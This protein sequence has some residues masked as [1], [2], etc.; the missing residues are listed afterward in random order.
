MIIFNFPF[1]QFLKTPCG[2]EPDSKW[3]IISKFALLK[4]CIKDFFG[5]SSSFDV[6]SYSK[7]CIIHDTS[8]TEEACEIIC[9]ITIAI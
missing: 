3:H 5:T 9:P 8:P 2:L 6:V 1:H 4:H 7:C